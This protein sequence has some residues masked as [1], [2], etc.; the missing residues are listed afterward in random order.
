MGTGD[1]DPPPPP[2]LN[3][4]NIGLLSNTGPG[5]LKN[6]KATNP[7]FNVGPSS[8]RQRNAISFRADNDPLIVVFRSFLHSST[9]KKV[10]KF[11][12]PLIKLSGSAHGYD[13]ELLQHRRLYRIYTEQKSNV[14][15]IVPKLLTPKRYI[16]A[17]IIVFCFFFAWN[18]S[19]SHLHK[20]IFLFHHSGQ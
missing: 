7:A 18:T 5:P 9:K 14:I 1:P 17:I 13:S 2:L 19:D 8:A 12:P 15:Y 11:G 10:I 4:K 3:H 20:G 6:H 16:K